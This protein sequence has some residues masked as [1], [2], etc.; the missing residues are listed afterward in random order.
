V[1]SSEPASAVP[2]ADRRRA[3]ALGIPGPLRRATGVRLAEASGRAMRVRLVDLKAASSPC[4][5]PFD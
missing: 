4:E 1:R 3:Q 5:Q 2:G